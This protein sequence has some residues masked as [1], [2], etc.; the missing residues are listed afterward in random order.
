M[1]LAT[2]G[3]MGGRSGGRFDRD[4]KRATKIEVRGSLE[5][6][7]ELAPGGGRVHFAAPRGGELEGRKRF[8]D[9]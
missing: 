8:P 3:G 1:S 9:A 6:L 7:G 5:G 4:V 2:L